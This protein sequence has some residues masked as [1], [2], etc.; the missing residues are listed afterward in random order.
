MTARILVVD[1]IPANVKLLEAK[2]SAE[3]FDVLTAADGISALSTAEREQPDIILLDVMMPV[4]NGWECLE[5]LRAD[6][7]MND[8]P[9]VMLTAMAQQAD[10]VRGLAAGAASF[11]TKPFRVA[12]L[13]DTIRQTLSSTPAERESLRRRAMEEAS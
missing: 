5:A 10:R 3:Y 12:G 11:V 8:V 13:V 2:L 7:S 1:D 6:A 9:V 4:M